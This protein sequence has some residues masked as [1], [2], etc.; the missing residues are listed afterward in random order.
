[1]NHLTGEE[2][3]GEK[4]N[5]LIESARIARG[6]IKPISNLDCEY[7]DALI[8]PGGFGVAKNLSNFAVTLGSGNG[9]PDDF[10]VDPSVASVIES[11]HASK[12]VIGACC[13]APTVVAKVIKGVSVTLGCSSGEMFPY[14][15]ATKAITALGGNH[16]E[17]PAPCSEVCVDKE[18]LVVTSGGYMYDGKP[19]QIADSVAAMVDKVVEIAN[20]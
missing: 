10:Q 14:A 17:T 20:A 18:N 15:G 9:G 16:V 11:F 7:F 12:K 3:P 2:I 8:I 5:V 13:I 1:M 19:H 4:R 6:N